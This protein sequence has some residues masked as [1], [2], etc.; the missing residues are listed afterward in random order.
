VD[1][2]SIVV[3][4]VLNLQGLATKLQS[5]GIIMN[6]NELLAF[7]RAFG[8]AQPL[9]NFTD[10]GG[11][12]ERADHKIRETM[13][14]YMRNAQCKQ[15]LFAPC[16]DNGYLPVLESYRREHAA[17]ITLIETRPAE[18]GFVE[19][20]LKRISIPRV[21]RSDNLPANPM[22]PLALASPTPSKS[23]LRGL[24]AL[25][26]NSV[27][28]V[29]PVAP[30][31]SSPAP[32]IDSTSSAPASSWAVVGKSGVASKTINIAPKKTPARKFI[33]LNV[34][35]DRL[36]AELPRSDPAAENRYA[37][38]LKTSGKCCNSYHLTG[39]CEAGE[40][41]DYVHGEKLSPGEL[42]VLKHKARS[43]SCVNKFLCR[44]FNCTFGHHCKFGN[45]CMLDWCYFADSHNMDLEPARRL[46]EDGTEEWLTS[47]LEKTR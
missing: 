23:T 22:K 25:Q 45:R 24:T 11:G 30:K 41:C 21:F 32:S 10:V 17:R 14:L 19:L 37:E 15:V 38:R 6:G 34:D 3:Q 5:C 2:W 43:R 18:P 35:G 20:G 28:F 1:D 8:L 9:F 26:A 42:L 4:V 12:K 29:P 40:Y 39:K 7:G 16:H 31:S 33:L 47:Y 27:A 46:Y 44:D 13:R 36:D